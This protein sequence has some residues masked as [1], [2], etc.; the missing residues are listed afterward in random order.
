MEK[1]LPT[2]KYNGTTILAVAV[3]L[4]LAAAAVLSLPRGDVRRAVIFATQK[5]TF[6]AGDRILVLAPHPDDESI[7][8]G[9]VIQQAVDLGLPVHVVF[10]TYGDANQWSFVLYRKRPEFEPSQVEAMGEVR[11]D[12]A[13][14]ATGLLG[15]RPDQL[16]FL[17]YP[18]FGTLS[19][20]LTHWRDEPPL[21]SIFARATQVPYANAYQP[22]APYKGEEILADLTAAIKDFRPTKVFL[23]HPADHNP[24]HMALYVFA[25]V[26]L[27]D[28]GFDAERHPFLVHLPTWP[29]PRGLAPSQPL[30]PPAALNEVSP[31]WTLPLERVQVDRKLAA[32]KAHRT[33]YDS[34]VRYLDSFIRANELFGDYPDVHLDVDDAALGSEP[35]QQTDVLAPEELTDT[36]RA[37]FIGVEWRTVRR[38]DTD[39]TLSVTLSRPLAK[40]V[41]LSAYLFGYRP[42]RPYAEMPKIHVEVGELATAVYDQSRKLADPG[43]GVSRGARDIELRVP[44]A[45]LGAPVRAFIYARTYLGDLPLDSAAWRVLDLRESGK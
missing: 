2:F 30:A 23:S 31:W 13:L 24:D 29:E 14:A 11:H 10:L 25:R 8:C 19:I 33:Q 43:V 5:L 40:G 15:L 22:G 21:R 16:T 4:L 37:S 27:W 26:A 12:E 32:L 28:L 20:W 39:L 44:L 36:E 3:L 41:G 34:N 42:D 38:T 45:L 18:D 6:D 7:A 35:P 9:G 17:G 1:L